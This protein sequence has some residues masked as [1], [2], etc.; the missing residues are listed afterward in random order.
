MNIRYCRGW[1]CKLTSAV[2]LM[3]NIPVIATIKD[4]SRYLYIYQQNEALSTKWEINIYKQN[5]ASYTEGTCKQRFTTRN[6]SCI[7]AVF[8]FLFL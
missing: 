3:I 4:I 2:I 5:K 8:F 7:F 1:T 6:N